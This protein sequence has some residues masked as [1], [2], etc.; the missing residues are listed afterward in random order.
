MFGWQTYKNKTAIEIWIDVQKLFSIGLLALRDANYKFI[1]VNVGSYGKV[2]DAGVFE[3][4][5]LRKAIESGSI[6]LPEETNLPGSNITAPYVF[7]GDE[8]FPLTDYLM[9]PFPRAQLQDGE[10]NDMFNYRLCRARMS[11]VAYP[12][13]KRT[14]INYT[15]QYFPA[16]RT[17]S[18]FL[19]K[20]R[21]GL[22]AR[23]T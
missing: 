19:M 1:I 15:L 14:F 16:K 13:F 23:N 8:A 10:E 20:N 11:F 18:H 21:N 5:P 17:T 12:N 6:V 2:S 7:L 3:N 22:S 4:S 9:R